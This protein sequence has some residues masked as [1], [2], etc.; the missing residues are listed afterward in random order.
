MLDTE[1]GEVKECV[2]RHEGEEVRK[3]Y[4]GLPDRNL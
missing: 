4:A 2:L 1:T 3:F